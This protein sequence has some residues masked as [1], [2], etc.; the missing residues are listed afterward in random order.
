MRNLLLLTMLAAA[1]LVYS[2]AG[3]TAAQTQGSATAGA[4]VSAA[5]TQAGASSNTQVSGSASGPSA[6][7]GAQNESSANART[8]TSPTHSSKGAKKENRQGKNGSSGSASLASGTKIAA[9]LTKGLDSRKAKPGDPVTAKVTQNVRAANGMVIRRG[10]KLIGHVTEAKARAKGDSESALGIVFEK[11]ISKGHEIPLNATVQALAAGQ[12]AANLAAS[13]MG[14]GMG[15]AGDIQAGGSAGPAP[16]MGGGGGLVRGAGNSVG[17]LGNTAG[18]AAG[19]VGQIA[20]G[21]VGAATNA[22]GGT[23]GA[24]SGAATSTLNAGTT[25]VVGLKGLSLSSQAGNATEGSLITSTGKNVHL[26]SGTQM[27]LNVSG[28]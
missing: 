21:A 28:K 22:A 27:I 8:E 10:S 11:A 26:D 1:V 4:G 18:G 15:G 6:T 2:A 20:G 24:V 3:Q 13:D 5:G 7:A 9:E 19:G 16:T 12:T 25:G 14:A 23:A 17:G